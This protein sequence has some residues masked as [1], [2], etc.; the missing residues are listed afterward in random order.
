MKLNKTQKDIVK[1][2]ARRTGSDPELVLTIALKSTAYRYQKNN[3]LFYEP[4]KV[5]GEAE[6]T[7]ESLTNRV[8]IL[9]K[10][11]L[12]QSKNEE[13]IEALTERLDSIVGNLDQRF[14]YYEEL[15]S[16]TST[17]VGKNWKAIT[18]L[19][20]RLQTI[21]DALNKWGISQ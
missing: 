9:Q 13:K 8:N 5:E 6:E 10:E 21:E 7:I 20:H 15:R 12:R 1:D 11:V 17:S 14:A 19:N 3:T 16:Q 2:L 4:I 18:R